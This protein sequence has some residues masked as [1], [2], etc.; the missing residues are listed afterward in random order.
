ME[1]EHTFLQFSS[2]R[3]DLVFHP[4]KEEEGYQEIRSFIKYMGSAIN[5]SRLYIDMMV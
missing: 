2:L 5:S 4:V 1:C 3:H